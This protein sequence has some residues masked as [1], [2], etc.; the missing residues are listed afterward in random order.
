MFANNNKTYGV[1]L[2][3]HKA[4]QTFESMKAA[5]VAPTPVTFTSLLIAC[6]Y[7][8]LTKEAQ[9]YYDSMVKYRI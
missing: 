8:G 5:G 1:N 4:I 9:Y 3:A 6:A 2:M 7:S